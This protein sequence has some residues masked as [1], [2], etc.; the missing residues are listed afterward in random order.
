MTKRILLTLFISLAMC[1]VVA[2]D[3][4]DDAAAAGEKSLTVR[5]FQFKHKEA[6]KAAALIKALVSAEGSVSLQPGTNSLVV[7]DKAENL[8][9]IAD[10]LKQYD[11][12]P[13]PLFLSVRLVS[14]TRVD[15]AQASGIPAELKDVAVNLSMFGFNSFEILG[16]ANV[17]GREGEPGSI[18]LES[19]YRADF[20][21]GEFDPAS[22]T[23]RLTDFR[24]S[25]KQKDQLTQLW[26]T[27]LN[28][29][30]GQTVI[31]GTAKDPQSQRMMIVVMGAKK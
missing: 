20:K 19:G 24:V 29:K 5:S 23:V 28:L 2:A 17:E 15:A 18:E 4:V 7:T 21:F 3:P 27:T 9:A 11:T 1:S 30:V 8:R 13:Q 26:K 31:Y 22:R 25:K 10:M 16:I 14:A 12:P 6:D